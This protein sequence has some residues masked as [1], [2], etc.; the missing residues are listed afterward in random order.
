MRRLRW[1]D[2]T[3]TRLFL[4]SVV[5]ALVPL[6]VATVRALDRGWLPVGDNAYFAIRAADVFSDDPPLLGT[7]TSNSLA[8]GIDANNPGPLYFDALAIPARLLPGG[9][10]LAIGVAVL[11]GLAVVAIAVMARRRAG[12][13]VGMLATAVTAAL[14]WA[15]GSELLFDPW[16]PHAMLLPSSPSWC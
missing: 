4:P 1:R 2:A 14:C 5:A 16:Q 7:W 10:G 6:V 13:L 12:P 8:S 3:A 15:M 9:P 11:N